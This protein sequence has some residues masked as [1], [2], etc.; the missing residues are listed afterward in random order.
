M[1]ATATAPVSIDQHPRARDRVGRVIA[2]F[3]ISYRRTWRGSVISSFL[4][5]VLFL[6]AMGVGLGDLVD[7]QQSGGLEGLSYLSFIGPG[8]LAATAMQVA[9]GESTW[10][11]MGGIK[12]RR[13]YH[14]MLAT[15][16]NARDIVH[17]HLG[18]V[19]VRLA[20]TCSI[21]LA[22]LAVFGVV[23]SPWGIL[24][25]P[26]G[27]LTGLAFAA[28]ITAFAATQEND[29]SFASLMRFGILPMFL[30]SGTFFPIDQLPSGLQVVAR[31]TPLWHGVALSRDLCL[32]DAGLATS[33]GH[34]LYL[35]AWMAAGTIVARWTFT[36]RLVV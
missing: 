6:L 21:F 29:S 7:Q 36:K 10:P 23:E 33:A 8:L 34:V 18:W 28:P 19:A 13:G 15:P 3:A 25:S 20:A 2:G 9:A 22:V 4:N 14:A 11:V 27:I 1:T 12:W 16:I 35:L 5:P 30:F 24:A 26:A 32:G 31:I 17:G